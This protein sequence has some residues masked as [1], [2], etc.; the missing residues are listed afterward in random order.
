MGRKPSAKPAQGFQT[1]VPDR[2]DGGGVAVILI[3]RGII[4][5]VRIYR[6]RGS[7]AACAREW[8][9]YRADAM[10]VTM[11]LEEILAFAEARGPLPGTEAPETETPGG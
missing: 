8:E 11:T 7:A 10:A 4:S 5:D 6:K 2:E 3:C 9:G 1:L